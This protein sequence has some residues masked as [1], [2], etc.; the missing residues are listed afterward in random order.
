MGVGRGETP[1]SEAF[2]AD[3]LQLVQRRPDLV[4]AAVEQV[5]S[6]ALRDGRPAA[7]VLDPRPAAVLAEHLERL[8]APGA[9]R[10]HVREVIELAGPYDA[11][12]ASRRDLIEPVGRLARVQPDV[13]AVRPRLVLGA[14]PPGEESVAHDR[15]V[16]ALDRSVLALR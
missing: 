3:V 5:E 7:R 16:L 4:D 13:V 9:Q 6:Q 12:V 11:A 10:D 14:A 2:F 8:A 15:S 1:R